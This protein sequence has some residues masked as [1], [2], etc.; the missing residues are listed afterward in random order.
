M[1][2]HEESETLYMLSIHGRVLNVTEMRIK[3]TQFIVGPNRPSHRRA[4]ILSA[5]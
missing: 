2:D 5:S 3:S 4:S 1:C